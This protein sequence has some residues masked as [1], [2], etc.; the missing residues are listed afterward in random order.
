MKCPLATTTKLNLL[1]RVHNLQKNGSPYIIFTVL[2]T[3][4]SFA[5]FKNVLTHTLGTD[6]YKMMLNKQED[7]HFPLEKADVGSWSIFLSVA[8]QIFHLTF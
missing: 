3:F 1:L 4:I 8:S 7:K 5:D 2:T 6:K